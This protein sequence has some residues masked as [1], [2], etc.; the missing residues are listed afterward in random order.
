MKH[1]RLFPPISLRLLVALATTFCLTCAMLPVGRAQDTVTGAF[2][3]TVTNSDTGEPIVGATAV[4]INQQTNQTYPKTSDARGRFYQG[5]L[6]PGVYTI[7]VSAPGYVTKEVQQRLFI[8]R[9]GE[10][11]PVPVA[12]DP[13]PPGVQ[14]TPTPSTTTN[15]TPTNTPSASPTPATAPALS[16]EDT[17]IRGRIN[18]AD[19]RQGDSFT[20]EEVSTLPLG[21]RTI[22]RTFDE[23]ALLLPGVAPPP[24]TLGEVAGP[25]VGAGGGSAGPVAVEG[26]RLRGN[27]FTVDGS[28]NNDEDIGVRRQGFVALNSQPIESVKEYQAI[29]LLAP[30]QFG[31]NIGAQVNAVS[32]SGGSQTHGTLYGFFNS[33]QLNARNV[34]DTAFG[35][36]VTALRAGNNQPVLV[37][38]QQDATGA[39]P[40][41]RPPTG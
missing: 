32:K 24:Q 8:T 37:G 27:N 5:L 21:G 20:E 17:D 3:G 34:F 1:V 4:I 31:R 33:S 22:T 26:L 29:T 36:G 28:D 38:N 15:P 2:E 13:A 16:E 11:V 39:I 9:T 6:A 41:L 35:N 18:A 23:L 25:G 10:V 7:R 19:A 12:L 30:A 40:N 14:P